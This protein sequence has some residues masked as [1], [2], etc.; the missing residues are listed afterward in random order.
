VDLAEIEDDIYD[1]NYRFDTADKQSL[2]DTKSIFEVWPPLQ[3]TPISSQSPSEEPKK[4][5]HVYVTLPNLGSPTLVDVVGKYSMRLFV[6]S[7]YLT[8]IVVVISFF[9]LS[10]ATDQR[11]LDFL[12]GFR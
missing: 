1:G 9:L 3:A 10:T 7:E 8:N 11:E 12:F 6:P 2:R 5:L 4:Q